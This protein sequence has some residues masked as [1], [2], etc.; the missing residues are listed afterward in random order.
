MISPI[1]SNLDQ[2]GYLIKGDYVNWVCHWARSSNSKIIK[3][4]PNSYLIKQLMNFCFVYKA[5]LHAV[6]CLNLGRR[7]PFRIP[8]FSAEV[9]EL[10]PMGQVWPSMIQIRPC[11]LHLSTCCLWLIL[12]YNSRI[13]TYIYV[14]LGPLQKKIVDLSLDGHSWFRYSHITKI[15]KHIHTNNNM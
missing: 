11:L 8:C 13:H 12:H 15:G 7:I 5:H 2:V 10:Q 14:L 6:T 3:I 9:N 4:I 1:C